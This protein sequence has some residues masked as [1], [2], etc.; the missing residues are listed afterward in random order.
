MANESTTTDAIDDELL[1]K[2]NSEKAKGKWPLNYNRLRKFHQDKIGFLQR[3]RKHK[4]L[5]F[6]HTP[7]KNDL[8]PKGDVLRSTCPLSSDKKRFVK[9]QT[10]YKCATCEV[11]LCLTAVGDQDEDIDGDD[12]DAV[13]AT[14]ERGG[15]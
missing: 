6:H 9:R 3:L 2:L 4:S 10:R 11:P 5:A 7:V 15:T 14:S 12:E 8:S 13:Q 1:Q